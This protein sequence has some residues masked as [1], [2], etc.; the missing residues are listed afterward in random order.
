MCIT[1]EHLIKCIDQTFNL[2]KNKISFK[3]IL[4]A[5]AIFLGFFVTKK[6]YISNLIS[7]EPKSR[8]IFLIIGFI[9]MLMSVKKFNEHKR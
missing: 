1:N 9:M 2:R 3:Q 8:K 5:F 4:C 6:N 7:F